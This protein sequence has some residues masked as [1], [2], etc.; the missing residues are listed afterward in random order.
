MPR[1]LRRGLAAI[2][3]PVL[4]LAGCSGGQPKD[5]DG[6]EEAL[7][8]YFHALANGD[9]DACDMETERYREESNEAWEEGIDCPER[10]KQ[11][12]TLLEAFE[13]DLDDAE[14]D[15]E[16]DGDEATVHVEY[17]DGDDET[18]GLVYDDD[19]WLVDS[20]G[21]DVDAADE[22]TELSEDEAQATA[23]GWLAA[24]CSVQIG[25][26][27][28]EAVA[29]MGE[30]TYEYGIEDDSTPQLNWSLGAYDFTVFLDTD[31]VINEFGGSYDDLGESDL[32]QLPCVTEGEY[33]Y[34]RT[35]EAPE[36]TE[37]TDPSE[38]EEPSPTTE[39]GDL[40]S[41]GSWDIRVTEVVKSADEIMG[42]PNLYNDKPRGQ[43]VL[44][45]YEAT[46]TGSE[47]IAD[48]TSDLSWSFTSSSARVF[49]IAF[50]TTPAD[51][52]EWP[53]E[54]RSGGTIEQQE[55][56]DIPAATIKGGILTVEGYDADGEPVFADFPIR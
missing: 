45:T 28:D 31:D 6:A 50:Q 19:R 24:W 55:V 23:D 32:A 40:V 21:G 56:F 16:V 17:S 46:Y 36:D 34:E 29:L 33:G 27:R 30:P 44:I 38:T 35:A 37:T 51:S 47:R 49:D 9:D 10:V 26:T 1:P 42:R 13:V 8:D 11:A 53:Y 7:D 18:F 20:E 48:V 25:M 5:A 54:A 12:Q 4:L 2:V 52:Q 39:I 14:F 22:E 3:V 41:V 43:Y 15:A